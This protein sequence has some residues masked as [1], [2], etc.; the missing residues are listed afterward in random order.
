MPPPPPG[1][2]ICQ[3]IRACSDSNMGVRPMDELPTT[4]RLSPLNPSF[5]TF[6]PA[7]HS[8]FCFPRNSPLTCPTRGL[9]STH[10]FPPLDAPHLPSQTPV[11]SGLLSATLV[12]PLSSSLPTSNHL[13]FNNGWTISSTPAEGVG[14]RSSRPVFY[15]QS[16]S[17][18]FFQPYK[19]RHCNVSYPPLVGPDS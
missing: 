16:D 8:P 9:A 17:S 7:K 14:C 19:S 1:M 6:S 3:D 5:L 2:K 11:F 15:R 4:R 18:F 13:N 10:F 12:F